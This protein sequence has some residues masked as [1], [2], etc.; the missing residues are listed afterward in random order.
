MAGPRRSPPLCLTRPSPWMMCH[1]LG[2][3][4]T[5]RESATQPGTRTSTFH[6]TA[7]PAGMNKQGCGYDCDYELLCMYA[8]TNGLVYLS[9]SMVANG[10]SLRFFHCRAQ[11]VTSALSDRISIM[12]KAAWPYINLAPQVRI[13]LGCARL[14]VCV[15]VCVCVCVFWSWLCLSTKTFRCGVCRS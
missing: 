8:S 7:D 10:A 4:E 9:L 5:S 15:C 2:T 14:F 11:G 1:A 12:R 6:N 3:G 13:L